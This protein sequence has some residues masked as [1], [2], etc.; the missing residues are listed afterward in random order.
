M[1]KEFVEDEQKL[2]AFIL[3]GIFSG[4]SKKYHTQPS[5]ED[6]IVSI[7][8]ASIVCDSIMP[9]DLLGCS[10][11]KE[12]SGAL[13]KLYAFMEEVGK[14]LATYG[15]D[16]NNEFGGDFQ[17]TLYH[18]FIMPAQAFYKER[19]VGMGDDGK[20]AVINFFINGMPGLCYYFCTGEDGRSYIGISNTGIT[21][22]YPA[23]VVFLAEGNESISIAKDDRAHLDFNL[24]NW[25]MT[26]Y[27]TM[28]W[29]AAG[30]V[31]FI[32]SVVDVENGTDH[33]VIFHDS[34]AQIH[35]N[36]ILA[37]TVYLSG[38]IVSRYRLVPVSVGKITVSQ[39]V[40]DEHIAAIDQT[41]RL[42][43]TFASIRTLDSG[44]YTDDLKKYFNDYQH[45]KYFDDGKT[46]SVREILVDNAGEG[47]IVAVAKDQSTRIIPLNHVNRLLI[48]NGGIERMLQPVAITE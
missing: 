35:V 15:P 16:G 14:T 11:D 40:T 19:E 22:P 41:E 26:T 46:Y 18:K 43:N 25:L 29:V 21:W 17:T 12:V 44:Y 36:S 8:L 2:R 3:A 5:T 42:N 31:R 13:D 1:N 38:R 28:A 10:T 24:E 27:N 32:K 20:R 39:H 9:F 47:H 4:F 33:R 30:C 45:F 34:M 48:L 37:P 7:N 23:D 6:V